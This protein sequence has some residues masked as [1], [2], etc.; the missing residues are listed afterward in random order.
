MLRQDKTFTHEELRR[1][2]DIPGLIFRESNGLPSVRLENIIIK[3][4]EQNRQMTF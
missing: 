4:H 1:S 3:M 2:M